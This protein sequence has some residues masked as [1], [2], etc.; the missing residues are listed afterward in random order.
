MIEAECF[1]L[2]LNFFAESA[3][4]NHTSDNINKQILL[5]RQLKKLDD[6]KEKMKNETDF[7]NSATI[8]QVLHSPENEIQIK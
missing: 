5:F 3:E 7:V 4:G 2:D 6:E 8:G 1:E